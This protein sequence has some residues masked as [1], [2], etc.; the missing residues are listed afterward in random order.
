[1][2]AATNNAFADAITLTGASGYHYA[3][4]FGATAEVGEPTN[5]GATI[6][7]NWTCPA[8]DTYYFSTRTLDTVAT[9][10][11]MLTFPTVVQV[12]TGSAV[13]SLTEATYI[14]DHHD[15]YA[16]EF[17]AEVVVNCTKDVVYR[18]RVDSRDGSHGEAPI[19][20]GPYQ[21]HSLAACDNCP[22]IIGQGETCVG[23]FRPASAFSASFADFTVSKGLY[24]ARYCNGWFAGSAWTLVRFI[25]NND[26]PDFC[27]YEAVRGYRSALGMYIKNDGVQ[28]QLTEKVISFSTSA[29]VLAALCDNTLVAHVGG[30]PI[31]L[32]YAPSS[33]FPAPPPG[34]FSGC[35]QISQGPVPALLDG[36]PNPTWGLYRVT[37][38]LDAAAPMSNMRNCTTGYAGAFTITNLGYSEWG[39]VTVQILNQGQVTG[40]AAPVTM[41]DIPANRQAVLTPTLSFTRTVN[42]GTAFDVTLRIKITT[43]GGVLLSSLG[44]PPFVVDL[45]VKLAEW[46]PFAFVENGTAGFSRTGD[47]LAG[48]FVVNYQTPP[49]QVFNGCGF[50]FELLNTGG[51][52]GASSPVTLSTNSGTFNAPFTFNAATS[53]NVNL[54]AT[55][56]VYD[57]NGF[58]VATLTYD[59]T[60]LPSISVVRRTAHIS[61]GGSTSGIEITVVNHGLGPCCALT[62]ALVS[63]AVCTGPFYSNPFPNN[64][65]G[66]QP[67]VSFTF[68]F[69]TLGIPQLNALVG[70]VFSL[71]DGVETYPGVT[72]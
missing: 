61:C 45:K 19:R 2:P 44:L 57:N 64:L 13:G 52:S 70:S 21:F 71:T 3:A 31:R 33:G 12:F 28:T 29:L 14:V 65:G 69:T 41:S 35:V 20:W 22:P 67:G 11:W 25:N 72:I 34:P 30:D 53:G 43:F 50:K 40:A 51:I 10:T 17:G 46:Q 37:P 48:S 16:A 8:T 42:L 9:P 27:V 68:G 59:I 49:F 4:N 66:F 23:T 18:I 32:G 38:A 39:G 63:G 62:V 24:R 5:N 26:P 15:G 6:W 58:K 47:A 54:V 1:M 56:V 60:P 7:F 55:V 36:A